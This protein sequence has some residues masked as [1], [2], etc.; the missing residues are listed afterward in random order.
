MTSAITRRAAIVAAGAAAAAAATGCSGKT[1]L[2]KMNESMGAIAAALDLSKTRLPL[3][4][5]VETAMGRFMITG[6]ER[7]VREQGQDG[8]VEDHWY[9]YHA[10]AW[11][12][13]VA[14]AEMEHYSCAL[15]NRGDIVS[16][17]SIGL[18][19]DED[20]DMRA[21]FDGLDAAEMS[22]NPVRGKPM[23]MVGRSEVL[24][25]EQQMRLQGA[26]SEELYGERFNGGLLYTISSEA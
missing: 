1:E 24:V 21:Y 25:L 12:R 22:P 18:V 3:G 26:R 15:L 17:L 16:V 23:R 2:E 5:V 4:S 13:G 20:R 7:S 11:P 14:I 9:D 6:H 10:V 8:E 19:D